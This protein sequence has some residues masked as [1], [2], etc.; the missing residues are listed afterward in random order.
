MAD[1]YLFTLADRSKNKSLQINSGSRGPLLKGK[2]S[3]APML[4]NNK[5]FI[6]GR[7]AGR[8]EG[9]SNIDL[10]NVVHDFDWTLTPGTRRREVPYI[11]LSEM[12][13]DFNTVR[14]Q[15]KYLLSID[16]F[17][18]NALAGIMDS[19]AHKE[20]ISAIFNPGGKEGAEEG[21]NLWG[22]MPKKAGAA[23]DNA[24]NVVPHLAPYFGLYGLTP[25]GFEYAFPYFSES[26]KKTDNDWSSVESTNLGGGITQLLQSVIGPEGAFGTLVDTLGF[27]TQTLG[28]Y[29]ERPRM[30]DNKELGPS[31]SFSFDLF[32]T[33]SIDSIIRNWHLTFMLLYQNLPNRQSKLAL[34]P[35]VMYE[36]EVPGLFYSPFCYISNIAISNSGATR[37]MEVP[38]HTDYQTK[39]GQQG[40]SLKGKGSWDKFA[41]IQRQVK[42]GSY[43]RWTGPHSSISVNPTVVRTRNAGGYINDQKTMLGEMTI[44]DAYRV[45]ITL[46]SMIPESKNLY[47]HSILGAGTRSSGLYSVEVLEPRPTSKQRESDDY[48][49]PDD[50]NQLTEKQWRGREN[51]EANQLDWRH[52]IFSGK[53]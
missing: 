2:Q 22:S 39:A 53:K 44:P 26:S 18:T 52:G 30:Y 14:Q 13:V 28:T 51:A 7:D 46:Q 9:W 27:S 48:I 47:F 37:T 12:A 1:K 3:G 20:K 25:T 33:T 19:D 32:N 15:L 11:R 45:D 35:P 17:A 50:P 16:N 41:D 23:Q 42:N 29:I 31:L 21:S 34:D 36:V 6:P 38:Y 43:G 49:D 4:I 24:E 10:I 40:G 5:G 8:N